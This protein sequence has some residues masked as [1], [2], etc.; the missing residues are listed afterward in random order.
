MIIIAVYR[1]RMNAENRTDDLHGL[2]VSR[3]KRVRGRLA[4]GCAV[5]T[6]EARIA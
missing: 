1:V 6:I 3:H 5:A 4:C 2:R